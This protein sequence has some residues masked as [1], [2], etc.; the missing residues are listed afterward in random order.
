MNA[1]SPTLVRPGQEARENKA[2][3]YRFV[4]RHLANARRELAAA[5]AYIEKF[6]LDWLEN[7]EWASTPLDEAINSLDSVPSFELRG[8]MIERGEV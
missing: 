6:G 3:D 2:G 7:N 4:E 8:E 5:S 1:L